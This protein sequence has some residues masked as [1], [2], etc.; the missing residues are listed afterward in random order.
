MGRKV[1]QLWATI[2]VWHARGTTTTTGEQQSQRASPHGQYWL[3]SKNQ[4]KP[5][6]MNLFGKERYT[7]CKKNYFQEFEFFKKRY[8]Y[9]LCSFSWQIQNC[10]MRAHA[11]KSKAS[12]DIYVVQVHCLCISAQSAPDI[13]ETHENKP[14]HIVFTTSP[15]MSTN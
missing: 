2:T 7:L 9:M 3:R 11:T 4:P 15:A 5:P 12:S 1:R 13:P 6:I 14:R 8:S 10:I